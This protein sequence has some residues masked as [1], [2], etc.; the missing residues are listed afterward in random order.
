MLIIKWDF[1][2]TKLIWYQQYF[3][4]FQIQGFYDFCM[5]KI[6]LFDPSGTY[7]EI[8]EWR[9]NYTFAKHIKSSIN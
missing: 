7:R 4:S 3:A 1:K 5:K 6:V 9:G 2:T 8:Q